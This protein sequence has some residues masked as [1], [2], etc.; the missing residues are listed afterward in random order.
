MGIENKIDGVQAVS[1]GQLEAY[2]V[3]EYDGRS[4]MKLYNED[5][6]SSRDWFDIDLKDGNL[7][8][9]LED[10]ELVTLIKKNAT[11]TIS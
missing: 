5:G 7:S 9:G 2:D 11:I 3:F 6:V 10:Y 1:Y 4:Y 8:V